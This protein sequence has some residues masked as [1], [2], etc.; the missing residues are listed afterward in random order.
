MQLKTPFC[1]HTPADN[2]QLFGT[3]KINRYKDT[4]KKATLQISTAILLLDL[5]VA[6]PLA[7]VDVIICLYQHSIAI[8]IAVLVLTVP[9]ITVCPAIYAITVTAAFVHLAK[10]DIAIGVGLFFE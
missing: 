4:I 7:I 9:E 10:K 1:H 5:A 8:A 6:N 2:C 3:K